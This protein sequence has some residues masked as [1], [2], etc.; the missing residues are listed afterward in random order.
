MKK[1][2]K[3]IK[4]VKAEAK[5]SVKAAKDSKKAAVSKVKNAAKKAI[6]AAVHAAVKATKDKK[7]K[8]S[9]KAII[10]KH[11]AKV[12]KSAKNAL[13]HVPHAKQVIEDKKKAAAALAK[14][15][16]KSKANS[17]KAAT[18]IKDAK[19][20]AA[21]AIA[22]AHAEEEKA[23]QEAAKQKAAAAKISKK[24]TK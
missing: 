11:T 20:K 3:A 4:A 6:H 24:V 14:M 7:G 10:D 19:D 23:K 8:G 21:K 15:G 17:I 9:V 12:H 5:V 1:T 18:E 2:T 16:T 22:K 13:I